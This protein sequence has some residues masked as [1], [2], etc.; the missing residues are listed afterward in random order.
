MIK[1]KTLLFALLLVSFTACSSDDDE[2]GDASDTA[3]VGTW[4]ITETEGE[5]EFSEKVTFNANS[6][7]DIV[8]SYT[9]DGTTET[10]TVSF[11]WST[12]GNKLTLVIAGETEIVTYSISGDS[13]TI[14]TQDGD[15]IFTRQ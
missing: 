6:S 14:T 5:T 9:F 10:E 12:S 1:I 4:T 11:T 13:L 2:M 15:V 7:G 3:L 8:S